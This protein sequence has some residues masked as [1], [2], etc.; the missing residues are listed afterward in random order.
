MGEG[1]QS[2]ANYSSSESHMRS[3][4]VGLSIR[5]RC[6][7]GVIIQANKSATGWGLTRKF[8]GWELIV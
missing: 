6:F 1:A 4:S 8:A 2:R 5:S 7:S 3:G